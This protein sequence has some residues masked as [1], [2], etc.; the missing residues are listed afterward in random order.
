[1]DMLF[2]TLFLYKQIWEKQGV[3]TPMYTLQY[4]FLNTNF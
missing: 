2:S 1:M 4:K 3:T